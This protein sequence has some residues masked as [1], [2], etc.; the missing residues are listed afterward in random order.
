MGREAEAEPLAQVDRVGTRVMVAVATDS[1]AVLTV[2]VAVAMAMV[3]AGE[4]MGRAAYVV[5]AETAVAIVGALMEME[6]R[7]MATVSRVVV[8]VV[9]DSMALD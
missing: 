4:Q 9:A 1:V 3:V 2:M 5:R 7:E 8:A 6:V